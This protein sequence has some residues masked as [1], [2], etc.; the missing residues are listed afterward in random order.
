MR[1]AVS[2]APELENLPHGWFNHGP[3]V[4]ALLEQYRPKV[5]VELGTFLG[6]SAI[7][8]ARSARR[9]GGTV[10][11]VDTWAGEMDAEG[12]SEGGKPPLMLW[13]CAREMV[14]AGVGANVRLIPATTLEAARNWSLPIDFLYV[15]ADHSAAGTR[16]DLDVWVPHVKTGW[17]IAGDDYEHPLYPGV[18]E[19]WDAFEA[20][21]GLHLT[22]FQSN[23]PH[24]GGV[25]LIYGMKEF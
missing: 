24:P 8:M 9:W 15:D 21:H 6:A 12:G 13:S 4:L 7:A 5:I 16:A 18:R 1:T 3:K 20:E 22:R 19:A 14:A 23:P 25:Q 2:V 10:T 11:C 17:L